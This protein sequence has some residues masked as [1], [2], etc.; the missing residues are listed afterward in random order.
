MAKFFLVE[1]RKNKHFIGKTDIGLA[2]K[3][4]FLLM[5]R[6]MLSQEGKKQLY[7]IKYG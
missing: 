3:E 5:D 2:L 4:T 6:M 1:L 7:I